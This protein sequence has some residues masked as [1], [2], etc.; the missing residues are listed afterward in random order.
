MKS[1]DCK[2]VDELLAGISIKELSL[3]FLISFGL[4]FYVHIVSGDESFEERGNMIIM[5]LGVKQ[6]LIFIISNPF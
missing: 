2:R 6:T 4:R 1:G 5:S 3:F